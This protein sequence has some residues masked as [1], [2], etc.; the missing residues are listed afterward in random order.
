M[1]R[2]RSSLEVSSALCLQFEGYIAGRRPD[3]SELHTP[4]TENDTPPHSDKA[5]AVCTHLSLPHRRF[6]RRVTPEQRCRCSQSLTWQK[7]TQREALSVEYFRR[8][9]L[10]RCI[11]SCMKTRPNVVLVPRRKRGSVSVTQKHRHDRY[12][13]LAEGSRCAC[14]AWR[15]EFAAGSRQCD[16]A[17]EQGIYCPAHLISKPQ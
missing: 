13:S 5:F 1:K 6:K 3:C 16:S 4:R 11:L 12:R 14:E 10:W 15:C 7:R 17:A 9:N 8:H 2:A